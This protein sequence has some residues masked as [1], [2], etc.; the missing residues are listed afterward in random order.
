M[1]RTIVWQEVRAFVGA[2]LGAVVLTLALLNQ[3]SRGQSARYVLPKGS[4]DSWTQADLEVW[5][6]FL[7]QRHLDVAKSTYDLTPQ[8]EADLRQRLDGL[9]P[10]TLAYWEKHFAEYQR[11]SEEIRKLEADK[12]DP[13]T[14][15]RLLA[16]YEQRTDLMK[17]HPLHP[18]M[19]FPAIEKSLPQAQVEAAE[20][21][22][23][24]AGAAT[25]RGVEFQSPYL[26]EKSKAYRVLRVREQLKTTA[27]DAL[28]PWAS[29]VELFIETYDLDEGQQSTARSIL[30]E[31]QARRDEYEQLYREEF[32]AIPKNGDEKD[33]ASRSA[34][35]NA[36]IREMFD[37]LKAR[38]DRIPRPAQR[39]AM[40]QREL[41][42]RTLT[43]RP[44][45]AS[46]PS[47]S[48]GTR[49]AGR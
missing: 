24:G 25:G 30:S 17:R 7:A 49:P 13:A 8:Q 5:V 35:L 22:R 33:R 3:P 40:A 27:S 20:R 23:K 14:R 9:K 6:D 18:R 21:K 16:L 37:E 44:A 10:E 26:Q 38:L 36:P 42:S 45:P 28:G 39:D 43:T 48:L 2:R 34:E 46:R 1:T 31:L 29:Y 15:E 32:Q 11:L 41:E 4:M 19:V 47:R 12:N